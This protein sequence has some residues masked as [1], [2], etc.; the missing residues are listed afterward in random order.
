MIGW[1]NDGLVIWLVD[2]MIKC[3]AVD[4]NNQQMHQ[5]LNENNKFVKWLVGEMNIW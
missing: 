3:L 1:W 2:E 4:E 5:A